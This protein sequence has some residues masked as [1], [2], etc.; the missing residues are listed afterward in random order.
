MRANVTLLIHMDACS[1]DLNDGTVDVSHRIL[2]ML[3]DAM[4]DRYV[5]EH[6]TE[7]LIVSFTLEGDFEEIFP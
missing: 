7:K 1:P 5:V 6:T 4:P 3:T 2:T